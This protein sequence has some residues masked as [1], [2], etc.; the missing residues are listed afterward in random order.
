LSLIPTKEQCLKLKSGILEQIPSE[1]ILLIAEDLI[2][3][4]TAIQKAKAA[5]SL[6]KLKKKGIAN[7]ADTLEIKKGAK[8][9]LLRNLDVASGLVNGAI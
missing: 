5:T 3:A 8:I 9:M 1:K 6:E 4:M 2:D 7:L